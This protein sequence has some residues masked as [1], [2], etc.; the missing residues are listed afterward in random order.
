[1]TSFRPLSIALALALGGLA[2]SASADPPPIL[3]SVHSLGS[4][5]FVIMETSTGATGWSPALTGALLDYR[6]IELPDGNLARVDDTYAYRMELVQT[7]DSVAVNTTQYDTFAV[8]TVFEPGGFTSVF[9]GPGD[10][11]ATA[12]GNLV[13][14]GSAAGTTTEEVFAGFVEVDAETGAET[15]LFEI[16]DPLN[17]PLSSS[18]S[19]RFLVAP[20]DDI[21]ILFE[22]K[23]VGIDVSADTYSTLATPSCGFFTDM[24]REP[25][26][27]LLVSIAGATACDHFVRLDPA[28]GATTFHSTPGFAY[29][30][31]NPFVVGADGT[32]V[33]TEFPIG[34]DSF[35]I[36]P[37][38][39]DAT[40]TT[41]TIIPNLL[42]PPESVTALTDTDGD[43]W[44]DLTDNCV[45]TP[46]GPSE[47]ADQANA[48]LQ[49]DAFGD[50]CDC[51]FYQDGG[52]D[53]GDTLG[54]IYCGY[55]DPQH[56]GCEVTDMNGNGALGPA[57]EALPG[58][59]DLDLFEAAMADGKPGPSYVPA[60][61]P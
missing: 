17:H 44:A 11:A 13:I 59:T 55:Y 32:I 56:P 15:V 27:T 6:L 53:G 46:N 31:Y 20:N 18:E 60:P 28:T 57:D 2:S 34:F 7:T 12:D 54:F 49:E 35:A 45:L 38:T 61:Q 26:G 36:D 40:V 8:G 41:S 47:T 9:G 19:L 10:V 39:F 58:P 30:G 37:V 16:E 25:G 50:A 14:A 51:D 24:E 42:G 4:D 3:G 5:S 23:V 52:C 1:M 22:D 21:W 33:A 43:G 48:N 29:D